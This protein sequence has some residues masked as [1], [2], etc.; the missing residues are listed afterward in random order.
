MQCKKPSLWIL[1][2]CPLLEQESQGPKAVHPHVVTSVIVEAVRLP[3]PLGA[4]DV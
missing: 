4:T 1:V 2:R 3:A